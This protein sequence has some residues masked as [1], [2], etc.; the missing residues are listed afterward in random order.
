M[1][2][3]TPPSFWAQV[4]RLRNTSDSRNNAH[5]HGFLGKLA[6]VRVAQKSLQELIVAAK[7][8]L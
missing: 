2:D 5:G 8:G 1:W 3:A 7:D 6:L 4:T